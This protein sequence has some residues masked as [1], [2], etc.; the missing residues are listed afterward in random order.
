MGRPV[1]GV[2]GVGRRKKFS[3]AIAPEVGISPGA[4]GVRCGG[5]EP[6]GVAITGK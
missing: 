4:Y 1:E 2:D 5:V 6:T 3:K